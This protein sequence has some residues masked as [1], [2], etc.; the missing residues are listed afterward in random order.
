M[1]LATF[2]LLLA[3]ILFKSLFL[4]YCFFLI[5]ALLIACYATMNGTGK[6]KSFFG[7]LMI[8]LRKRKIKQRTEARKRLIREKFIKPKPLRL[9]I[10]FFIF[11]IIVYIF[12]SHT[13]FFAVVTSDSMYPSFKTGDLLMM[14]N[15]DID[16]IQV[17]DVIMFT[18]PSERELI[19][20]RVESIGEE[21]ILTAGDATGAT[22]N[23][24]VDINDVEAE[25]VIVGGGPVILKEAGWYFIDNAPSSAPFSG[26]LF[27]TS[28]LLM[29]F[30]SLGIILFVVSITLY[31]L[32]T[33]RD[34]KGKK[35]YRRRH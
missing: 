26:E 7:S 16:D 17:G 28:M 21:G 10:P 29:T 19:I 30:K 3:A 35:V 1:I 27:F 2:P 34:V 31:L 18:V 33:A 11:L 25:L 8:A 5:V 24:I 14:R 22:D 15:V 32:L 6:K 9:F 20:H 12:L 13:I 23:W 4:L